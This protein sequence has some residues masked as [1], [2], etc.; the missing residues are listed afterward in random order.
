MKAGADGFAHVFIDEL[1]DEALGRVRTNQTP[2]AVPCLAP[3][4]RCR[5]EASMAHAPPEW[6]S[7]ARD[8]ADQAEDTATY[9]VV[10]I[11]PSMLSSGTSALEV[12]RK[13]SAPPKQVDEILHRL[14]EHNIV[15]SSSSGTTVPFATKLYHMR[16]EGPRFFSYLEDLLSSSSSSR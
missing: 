1:P 2:R 11:L 14:S 7:L 8:L 5:I 15:E 9:R 13:S 4:R 12:A 16:A 10:R 3:G 6:R